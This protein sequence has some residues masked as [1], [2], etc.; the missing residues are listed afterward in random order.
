VIEKESAASLF[1]AGAQVVFTGADTPAVADVATEKGKW[2]V[3][4]DWSGSCKA[5][6][7]LTA[8]YWVWGPVYADIAAKVQAGTYVPG[9]D[10][11]DADTGAL[12]L[13]G[14]M[15]GET[16]TAG[17]A[18]LPPEVIAEVKDLV[19]KSLV[20]D[21]TRFD[22]FSGPINDNSGKEIVPAGSALEQIDLDAFPE[23][24]LGCKYCMKWW[25]E[26]IT[27]ELPE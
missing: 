24:D 22:V 14:F 5:E 10:Y 26:G 6:R 16:M 19:A 7:C 18:S 15:E 8:P 23:Y 25:A 2:G 12:G 1:D 11:F 17:V 20:G 4:Y 3:T 9:W 21:F 13:F 27:A